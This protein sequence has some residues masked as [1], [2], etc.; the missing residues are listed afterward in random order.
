M[1][2]LNWKYCSKELIKIIFWL[3]QI[4]SFFFLYKMRTF[5]YKLHPHPMV[6]LAKRH[7][8]RL[9]TVKSIKKQ[10]R[11][12]KTSKWNRARAH[13]FSP[14]ICRAWPSFIHGQLANTVGQHLLSHNGSLSTLYIALYRGASQTLAVRREKRFLEVSWTRVRV[15]SSVE[16]VPG[17]KFLLMHR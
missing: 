8:S 6:L 4:F 2:K 15:L 7:V 11:P 13:V 3:C 14:L 10:F 1:V 16:I 12:N 9:R 5:E 17:A